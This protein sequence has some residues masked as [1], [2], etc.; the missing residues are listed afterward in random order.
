MDQ[1]ESVDGDYENETL[2]SGDP[3]K[4]HLPNLIE[5]KIACLL[6]KLENIVHIPKAVLDEILSELHYILSIFHSHKL[7]IEE[8]VVDE[9]F[10][11]FYANLIHWA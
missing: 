1:V 8:S 11:L 4:L 3:V 2:D 5:E 6:L 10:L 9:L 7:Q